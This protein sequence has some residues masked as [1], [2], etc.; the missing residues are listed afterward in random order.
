M[1][2]QPSLPPSSSRFRRLLFLA[3]VWTLLAA[4][5]LGQSPADTSGVAGNEPEPDAA[6]A[7]D[8]FDPDAASE[9]ALRRLIDR[10][11]DPIDLN[12]ARAQDLA[13][14]PA[15]SPALARTIVQ[16]R[17]TNGPFHHVRD[18]LDLPGVSPSVFAQIE[19]FL[20]VRPHPPTAGATATRPRR[21]ARLEIT[22]TLTRRIDLGRGFDGDTTRTTYL[23]S[24][25]RL[26]TRIRATAG[27]RLHLGLTLDKDPGE[28]VQWDPDTDQYGVGHVSATVAARDLGPVSSAVVGDYT[29]EIGQGLAFWPAGAFGKG[30]DA[31]RPLLRTGR[32]I[33]PTSTAEENRFFR[34]VALTAS[35]ARSTHLT[36]WWSRKRRDASLAPPS[37]PPDVRAGEAVRPVQSLSSSGL[38]RT[39]AERDRKNAVRETLVGMAA[40]WSPPRGRLGVA[41][42]RTTYHRPVQPPATPSRRFDPR[43]SRFDVASAFG[44]GTFG[45][46]TVFGEAARTSGSAGGVVAGLSMRARRTEALLLGRWVARTFWSLHGGTIGEQSGPPQNERGFYMGLR[47]QLSPTLQIAAY[48]DVYRFPWLRFGVP[49][50][51]DGM[52]VRLVLDHQPRPWLHQ[53][54]EVRTETRDVGV[55]VRSAD[56]RTVDGVTAQTRQ[57]VR[58]H[59]SFDFSRSVR[60]RTRLEH[61]WASG[62]AVGGASLPASRYRERGVL[63]FQDVRWRLPSTTVDARLA[64]FDTDGFASRVFAYENDLRYSFSVPAFQGRGRRAYVLVRTDLTPRWRIEAKYGVTT[65]RDVDAVGS[66]LDEVS[67]NRIRE[68]RVQLRWRWQR[69]ARTSTGS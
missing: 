18:L 40:T 48:T 15:L 55:D 22:Q 54:I 53:Y 36:A 21:D 30:R 47:S 8:R 20:A 45:P 7:L 25:E 63:L 28:P 3:G 60:L 33:V 26:L 52:D 44:N 29:V 23:G 31:V 4:P 56:G 49:R 38:H 64:L 11:A 59:G 10:A 57:S 65:F 51:S 24:P 13:A 35:P 2:Y 5:A 50:P 61:T 67:G 62:R 66:G 68:V 17:R 37:V 14:L 12:R 32:G 9:E 6:A 19:P 46:V 34:G 1:A 58:W 41:A 43:G 69:G 42:A 16:Q 39:H 27:R